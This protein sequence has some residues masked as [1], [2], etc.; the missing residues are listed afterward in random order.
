MLNLR[1]DMNILGIDPGSIKTGYGLISFKNNKYSCLDFGVIKTNSKDEVTKRLLEIHKQ[2]ATISAK[3]K[4]E[5]VSIEDI[6]VKNNIHS[7][8]ILGQARGAAICASNWCDTENIQYFNF[9]ARQ[10]KNSITSHGGAPKDQVMYMIKLLL[11]I[12]DTIPEDA[13]D[14]LAA[15]ICAANHSQKHVTL[16]TSNTIKDVCL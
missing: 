13:S 11:N 10:I 5:I 15:A 7:A 4:P 16:Q 3:W 6:F 1:N 12:K 14:A 2:L 8:L 9:S